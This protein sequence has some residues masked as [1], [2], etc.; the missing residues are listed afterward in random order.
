MSPPPKV[1]DS[2]TRRSDGTAG[3]VITAQT[4]K[5]LQTHISHLRELRLTAAP[6]RVGARRRGNMQRREGNVRGV[7]TIRP[8]ATRRGRRLCSHRS[9]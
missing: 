2:S 3:R 9:L 1:T 6:H 7:E 5:E 4:V 8:L